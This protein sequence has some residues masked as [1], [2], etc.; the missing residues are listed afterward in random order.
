MK[1][2]VLGKK[3]SPPMV[4]GP[5][6][7]RLEYLATPAIQ[8]K[9]GVLQAGRKVARPALWRVVHGRRTAVEGR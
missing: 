6:H 4:W 1:A 7:V 3:G 5:G 2:G 9:V 8:R